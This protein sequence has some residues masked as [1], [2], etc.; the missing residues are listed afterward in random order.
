MA[1]A[2]EGPNKGCNGVGNDDEMVMTV[3]VGVMAVKM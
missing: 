1:G 3:M 2:A